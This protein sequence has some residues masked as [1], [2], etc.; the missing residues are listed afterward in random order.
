MNLTNYFRITATA[1]ALA[2][3]AASTT[4]YAVPASYD[5][6]TASKKFTAQNGDTNWFN[7]ANWSGGTVPGAGDDV[8]LDGDDKVVIDPALNR[9]AGKVQFQDLHLR[10]SASLETLPG[11]ILETRDELVEN[12]A[13]LIHRGSGGSGDTLVVAPDPQFCS[14]CGMKLNPSPKSK[15]IIVLQSSATVDMGLGGTTPA[16]LTRTGTG[17]LTLTAGAG[18]YATMT[19]DTLLIDGDLKLS[20]YYGFSPRPGQKFQIM[21]ANRSSRGEFTGLPEGGYVG[22]TEDNVGLRISYR[23]GDGNDVVLSAEQTH[24]GTCL[25]LP[26]VQKVREAAARAQARIDRLPSALAIIPEAVTQTREHILLARQVGV[27]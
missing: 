24:P 25:L 14:L 17:T 21:T 26:A 4:A 16:S 23:G 9:G 13:Q 1:A 27:P 3:T 6:L 19:A 10:D 2:F 12:Q 15:R 7:P 20:T 5:I 22:C 8:L 11:T 18:T